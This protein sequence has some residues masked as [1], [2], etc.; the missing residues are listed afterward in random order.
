[1]VLA[2]EFLNDIIIIYYWDNYYGTV[3]MVKAKV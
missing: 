1:M 3:G 2:K